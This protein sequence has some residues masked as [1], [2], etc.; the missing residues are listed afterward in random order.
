MQISQKASDS[1]WQI[2]A[3]AIFTVFFAH[4]PGHSVNGSSIFWKDF[5]DVVGMVGVPLFLFISGFFNSMSKTPLSKRIVRLIIPLLIWGTITYGLNILKTPTSEVFTGWIRWIYGCNNFLYF[6]PVLIWCTVLSKFIHPGILIA[7]GLCS[8]ILSVTHVI[9][10][11]DILTQYTN[12][13]NFIIYFAC[14]QLFSKHINLDILSAKHAFLGLA[15]MILFLCFQQPRYCSPFTFI[16]TISLFILLFYLLRLVHNDI[17]IQTGKYSYVIYLFHIQVA[18]FIHM[19][20][21]RLWG[22]WIEPIKVVI[23]FAV[24][25]GLCYVMQYCINKFNLSKLSYLLGFK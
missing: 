12:P 22:T 24:V 3:F 19:L 14:G 2:K 11:N 13:L 4:M 25:L 18:G 8:Q 10:Y 6:V 5:F 7:L 1:I 9:E 21:S 16:F 15:V 23:A 20:M 17:F